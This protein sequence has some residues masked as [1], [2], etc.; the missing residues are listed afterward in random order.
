MLKDIVK[1]NRS[2]RRF[3][4]EKEITEKELMEIID[5]ARLTPSAANR[6]PLRYMISNGNPTNEAIFSCL[7]WAGYLSDWDGPAE[8][9]KPSAYIVILSPEGI[10]SAQDEGIVAQTLL[11]CAVERGFGG[12][13]LG[14]VDRKRLA[15]LID[16]PQGYEI[17]LVIALGYPKEMVVIEEIGADGD[18]RYFRDGDGVHHVPKIKLEDLVIH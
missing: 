10:N 6:Q 12:C 4:Q 11:L 1:A 13:M 2:Y 14:N 3:Y 7:G 9:E 18:I 5:I 16:A 17:S 8:G 15:Q